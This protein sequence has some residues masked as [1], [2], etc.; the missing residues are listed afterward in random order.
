MWMINKMWLCLFSTLLLTVAQV[1][2]LLVSTSMKHNDI[3]RKLHITVAWFIIPHSTTISLLA[4]LLFSVNVNRKKKKEEYQIIVIFKT[5]VFVVKLFKDSCV[6]LTEEQSQTCFSF[7]YTSLIEFMEEFLDFAF[8]T[9][10]TRVGYI[11]P[12][13]QCK[14][15][16]CVATRLGEVNLHFLQIK[17]SKGSKPPHKMCKM[18]LERGVGVCKNP[19]LNCPPN[20]SWAWHSWGS[21]GPR[22]DSSQACSQVPHRGQRAKETPL[23]TWPDRVT[24]QR[25]GWQWW[26]VRRGRDHGFQRMEKK[27]SQECILRSG[28]KWNHIRAEALISQCIFHDLIGLYLHNTNSN[29]KLFRMSLLRWWPQKIKLQA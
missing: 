16:C 11:I 12:Q 20:A 7:A 23:L 2:V 4:I 13:A 18:C 27:G 17:S 9:A 28:K 14:I 3:C 10:T 21:D 19:L 25:G 29:A 5:D 26:Q 15:K 1:E 24:I 8:N 22:S 6:A